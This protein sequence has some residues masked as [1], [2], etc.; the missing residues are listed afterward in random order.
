MNI[1]LLMS[2][3]S[4][5]FQEAGY[6]YPKN[7]VEID[8]LPLVQRVLESL[9]SLHQFDGRFIY[10]IR[11]EEN[12]Q[13]HTGSVIRLLDPDAVVQE[14]RGSTAGAACTALLAIEHI[15]N[16]KP[17]VI[18]N[19]DQIIETNLVTTLSDFQYRELDGGIV[20]FEAVHP[21]WSYVRCNSE[22]LVVEAAEKRPISKL[23]TAGFYYF[24]RGKDFVN[25]TFEM[26]KKNDQVSGK[27][28]VCPAYNQMLLKQAKIGIQ[29]IPR[30][31]YHSLATPQGVL[32]YEDHLRI[33][34]SQRGFSPMT[35]YQMGAV[36]E[37]I[38]LSTTFRS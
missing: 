13:H 22:G 26:I 36:R 25:A 35:S 17:L 18:I 6:T 16:D 15:N 34:A 38:R 9:S 12:R 3:S 28:Y 11:Q 23:A 27:F 14:V 29:K 21:R 8:G 19:G 2:G 7:L 30:E 24:A 33:Q 31:A 5:V 10:L 20:V 1:L 37:N 4:D 32:A